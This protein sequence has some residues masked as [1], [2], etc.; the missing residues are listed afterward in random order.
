DKVLVEDWKSDMEG[1]LIF[2]CAGL[3]SMILTAFIVESYKTLTLDPGDATVTILERISDHIATSLNGTTV[4]M[5]HAISFIPTTTSLLCNTL[6]F[7]SLGLSLSSAMIAT[8]VEQWS[9]NF[10]YK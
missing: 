3:F 9:K 7:I 4:S 10:I 8:L 6:W 1:I 5:S 2:I